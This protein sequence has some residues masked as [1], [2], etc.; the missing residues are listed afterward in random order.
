MHDSTLAQPTHT[1]RELEGLRGLLALWVTIGHWT[2]V[3]PQSVAPLSQSLWSAEAVNVFIILSGFVISLLLTQTPVR[4]A[5][6]YYRYIA[7]R[8][9]RIWPAFVVVILACALLLPLTHTTFLASDDFNTKKQVLDLLA[10]SSE[11]LGFHLATHLTL[12]HGLVPLDWNR[13]ASYALIGQGW[14]VT[15]EWQF[16]VLAPLLIYLVARGGLVGKAMLV[17]LLAALYYLGRYMPAAY[18]GNQLV[19]FALGY[20]CFRVWD[21]FQQAATAPRLW[22]ARGIA[23][24]ALVIAYLLSARF[25]ASMVIWIGFFSVILLA[26]HPQAGL[27]QSLCKPLLHPLTQFLG[28]ISYTLYLVHFQVMVLVLA[29]LQQLGLSGIPMSGALLAGTLATAIPAAFL[30]SRYI[31]RPGMRLGKRL[32]MPRS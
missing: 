25:G 30:L 15:L 31:E 8:W 17:V 26:R 5:N 3:L 6:D 4:T 2:A 16:Y 1:I 27:E 24:L 14:S 11:H 23:I 22:L 19:Y 29:G 18:F 20:A 12:L 7:R 13:F 32:S 28:A 9:F 21:W 10:D